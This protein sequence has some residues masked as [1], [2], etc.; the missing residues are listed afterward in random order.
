LQLSVSVDVPLA[1]ISV[2]I[3]V[4]LSVLEVLSVTPVEGLVKLVDFNR[5]TLSGV[6]SVLFV[7]FGMVRL[8][9]KGI[10]V[11]LQEH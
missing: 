3:L 11:R 1:F 10:P 5:T 4:D 8:R 7:G 9:R 6:L 2:S